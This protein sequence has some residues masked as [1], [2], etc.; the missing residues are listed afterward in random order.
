MKISVKGDFRWVNQ[1]IE[2]SVKRNVIVVATQ[3]NMFAEYS[4]LIMRLDE[5]LKNYADWS[6]EVKLHPLEN[7]AEA[8]AQL[9]LSEKVKILPIETSIQ[10]VL[11][12][13][14]IQISI[15]STTFYD[16]LGQDVFNFA[17]TDSGV[18]SDYVS[19]V[20]SE[21]IAVPIELKEDIVEKFLNFKSSFTDSD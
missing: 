14:K 18:S 16:A 7:N 5:L 1:R 13:C 17:W 9:P 10:E 21:S 3:K 6:C 2:Q 12:S 8:Y 15:Y 20:I 11:A 4:R 19:E